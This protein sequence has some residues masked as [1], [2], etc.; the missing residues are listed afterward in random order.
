MKKIKTILTIFILL[1]FT[2]AC[3][4]LIPLPDS[5]EAPT[6]IVEPQP[7]INIP[8]TEA[9]VPRVTVEDAKAAFD[10]GEA[11]IVDVRGREYFDTGHAAGALSI[12]L[13]E[14]ETNIS[15]IDL[16]KDQWIITYCT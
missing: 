1:L 9:E 3:N 13:S 5:N 15:K 10:S 4:A 16:P 11:I 2:L 6:Q 7:N 14:F 8:L 12:P